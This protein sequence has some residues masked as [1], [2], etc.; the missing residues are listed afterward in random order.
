MNRRE[1]LAS[2]SVVTLAAGLGLAGGNSARASESEAVFALGNAEIGAPHHDP[3]RATLLST[4]ATLIYD[5]MIEQDADQSYHPH[6]AESWENSVDGM[7]W[8]FKLR[9]GV[10]F[11]DGEPFNAATIA[12]WIPKFKGSVNE[13]LVDA[14]DRVEVVDDFTVRFVMKR[15]EPNLIYNLAS[16]FM[17]IPSPKAYDA[18]G[19]N[20]GVTEAAGT[21]PYKFESFAVGQ[22]T[23][24]VANEDYN[25]GSDLSENKGAPY[26]KRLTLREIP[27]ASTA[28]LELK[29]GGV[30][31]LLGVPDQFLPQLQA[32]ETLGFR[33][34]PG[35][36]ITY[37]A[38]NTLAEPF[39]DVAVRQ[40]TALAV[41]QSAIL[42]SVFNG[43]GL[44]AHQFLISTLAESKIDPKLEIRHDLAKAN[45]LLDAA[46]WV[47][48]DD[49]LR[50]KDGKPL[51]VKLT[52]QSE[53]AFKRTAEILQAQ[54]KTIGMDVEIEIFDS[55]TIVDQLKKGQHQLAVRQ[56]GWNN[57]DILD[58]F[59]S[60]TNIPYPNS[61][62]WQDEK[63]Q[64]LRDIAMQQSKTLDERV[65]N[66][67]KYQENLIGNFLFVPIHE[68][69]LNYAFSET[70]LEVPEKLRGTQLVQAT[71]V[72]IKVVG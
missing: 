57:A 72:D 16:S 35:F 53:T 48:G 38:F 67:R 9:Q 52:A 36:G 20:F 28:F 21:G 31:L 11:H 15:A 46:G 37:L 44:E 43:V 4:V 18:A 55:T 24:L 3:I 61:S 49:G 8:T 54:L 5:R 14:V 25:W 29:T 60:T 70:L 1:F 22:E 32:E 33:S 66:F 51:K 42:K 30:G 71:T 69:I 65:A 41:D 58:W 39:G 56:Y 68:P 40:A 62:G 12:W 63:S 59:F 34:L 17:G 6:L 10:R 13:Y 45:Q 19:D 64:E 23:V 50:S 27:D 7:N 2:V 26:I 47:R